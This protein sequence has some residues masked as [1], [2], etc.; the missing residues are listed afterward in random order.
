MAA[1]VAMRA[2]T[3]AQAQRFLEAQRRLQQGDVAGA[4]RIARTLA[5]EVPDAADAQQLLAMCLAGQGDAAGAQAAF[6]RAL[7]LAPHSEVVALNYCAWLRRGGRA[8][9]ALH[10]IDSAPA[11]AQTR[12]QAGSI[13]LQLGEVEAARTAFSHALDLQPELVQAWHGLASALQA[14][15]ELEAADDALQRAIALAPGY[16]PAWVNRG[17]VLRMLGRLDAATDCL[18]Q[19][20]ALG[21]DT[22]EVRN[23]LL[24]LLQDRGQPAQA[25]AAARE[26]VATAPDFVPAHESLGHLLWEHGDV[27]APGEDPFA[28][29]RS[30]AAARRGHLPLQFAYARAL[31][32]AGH[33]QAALDWLQPLRAGVDEPALDWLLADALDRLDRLAEAGALYARVA[34]RLG[35]RHA[36][37]LNARARH[38]FRSGDLALARDCAERAVRGDPRNQEAWSLLGTA[39]RLAGD[40]REDWL[41]GYEHLVG[42]VDIDTPP[43][44]DSLAAFLQALDARLAGLHL[45]SREPRAQSVRG[46]TQTPGRL[47]GREDPLIGAAE[48]VLRDAVERWLAGLPHDADHPFLSRLRR[49]VR[50]VGSW[51]VR[52]RDAGHHANHIHDEGWLSS[53][54]YVA[55]PPTVREASSDSHAGW[56]QLGQPMDSLGLDLPPRRLIQPQAGR[57]AL[58]P[59]YVWHGTLPFAD[60]QPRVTI[61]FDMQPTG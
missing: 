35:D 42:V 15:G 44:Y 1:P 46:G 37:F 34:R 5:A 31:L 30:A 7:A 60:P 24:G 14:Q 20:Q 61:A 32:E 25:L 16:A 3:R 22:P 4:S 28:G 18:H 2:L 39:W 57:L 41:F 9:E 26:L 51:S 52:L 27:L 47:F 54:F 53:A 33:A 10:V 17:A 23:A 59:S 11:T 49:S 29:F 19:A 58:F 45:A 56:L 8:R 55:L 43:G 50:F 13:H 6:A 21:Q 12:L 48:Q 38:A 40:P 36:G